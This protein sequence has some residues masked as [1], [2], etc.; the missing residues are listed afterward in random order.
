MMI[1]VHT[2]R[3]PITSVRLW[4][5][6]AKTAALPENIAR[7]PLTKVRNKFRTVEYAATFLPSSCLSFCSKKRFFHIHTYYW[8]LTP[9]I[10][11]LN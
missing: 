2:A 3:L 11:P 1:P 5:V 10:F 6:S 8:H 7:P 4:I 9:F